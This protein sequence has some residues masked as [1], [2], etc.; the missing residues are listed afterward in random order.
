METINKN[1]TAYTEIY[2]WGYDI[3]GLNKGKENEDKS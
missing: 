3:F 2:T 1:N